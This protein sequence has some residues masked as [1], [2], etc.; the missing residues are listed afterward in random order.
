M[1][2]LWPHKRPRVAVLATTAAAPVAP[3]HFWIVF[4]ARA[5]AILAKHEHP[6]AVV[7]VH[8]FAAVCAH[9]LIACVA[10]SELRVKRHVIAVIVGAIDLAIERPAVRA[11]LARARA[12]LCYVFDLGHSCLYFNGWGGARCVMRDVRQGEGVF[13]AIERDLFGFLYVRTGAKSGSMKA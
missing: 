2:L 9:A 5:S 4:Y 13:Y 10:C 8:I 1:F 7:V 12:A 3:P 11:W 6:D